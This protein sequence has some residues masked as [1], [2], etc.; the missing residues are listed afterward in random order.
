MVLDTSDQ[1]ETGAAFPLSGEGLVNYLL[2]NVSPDFYL[3]GTVS[4]QLSFLR[5]NGVSIATKTYNDV[6]AAVLVAADRT[7]TLRRPLSS[8]Q[9]IAADAYIPLGYTQDSPWPQMSS[10]FMYRFAVDTY[11]PSTDETDTQYM[12]IGSDD[13]LTFNQAQDLMG[14][15]FTGE[16]VETG[17]EVSDIHIDAAFQRGET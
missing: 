12:M 7:E 17:W 9:Q 14:S 6:R 16:Y 15:L 3:E 4:D 10:R 2:T 5:Q 13:Q 8:L 1:D 11:N